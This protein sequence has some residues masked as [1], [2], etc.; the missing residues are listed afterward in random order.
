MSTVAIPESLVP[1]VDFLNRLESRVP[2][3]GLHQHLA[4]LNVTTDEL[5]PFLHFGETCYTR[6]LICENT[7]YELLCICW[8]NGQKSLIHNH[9]Q[10]T[11]GLRVITGQGIETT[12]VERADGKVDPV[13]QCVVNPGEICCTQDSDIHQ[14]A[15]EQADGSDLVTLHIYSP[16]LRTMQTWECVDA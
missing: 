8:K 7:W 9:A 12:F 3:D 14:V 1:L 13:K 6:N 4:Q 11:C 2:M 15:N 10:S 5:K 16:P